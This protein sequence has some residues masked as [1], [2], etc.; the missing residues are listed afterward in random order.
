MAVWSTV[1]PLPAS[2]FSP[3][4]GFEY[5]PGDVRKLPVTWSPAKVF[6]RYYKLSSA[7]SNW[8]VSTLNARYLSPLTGACEKVASDLRLGGDFH[9]VLR[10]PPPLTTYS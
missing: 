6:T 2:C 3:M 9:R 5:R 10:F 8:L 7:T 1:L 4:P